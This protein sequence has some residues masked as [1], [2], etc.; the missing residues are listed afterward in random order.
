MARVARL[1]VQIDSTG[2][3]QGA[4]EVNAALLSTA[5][6]AQRSAQARVEA[7]QTVARAT[8]SSN[9]AFDAQVK[10]MQA[11]QREANRLANEER[12][13]A[14]SQLEA[15]AA[16]RALTGATA[17]RASATAAQAVQSQAAA[18]G[19]LRT[20]LSRTVGTIAGAAASVGALTTGT[21]VATGAMTGLTGVL[22]SL[23]GPVGT[24]V[25]VAMSA[26]PA[27]LDAIARRGDESAE[28]MRRLRREFEALSVSQ[29]SQSLGQ[30]EARRVDLIRQLQ[31]VQPGDNAGVNRLTR[32]LLE[33]DEAVG[34]LSARLRALR[35]E[36]GG[37]GRSTIN[38]FANEL[39]ELKEATTRARTEGAAAGEAYRKAAAVWAQSAG[40]IQTLGAA[41]N[42]GNAEARSLYE[43]A[44]QI[45]QIH[46]AVAA[47]SKDAAAALKA[48]GAEQ[49]AAGEAM[50]DGAALS[51][52]ALRDNLDALNQTIALQ[53]A[54]RV[55]VA[56]SIDAREEENAQIRAQVRAL[57]QSRD[58]YEQV[59]VL[60]AQEKAVA[61]TRAKLPP[62]EVLAPGQAERIRAAV[63]ESAE[64]QKLLA[65]MLRTFDQNTTATREW[66]VAL[67]RVGEAAAGVAEMVSA[68]GRLAGA[69]GD[70]G[71]AIDRA[72]GGASRL[73][74]S[75][76]Q[77]QRAGIFRDANGV[78][79]N[80]GIGGAL[81]GAAGI[82]GQAAAVAGIA[83]A[84]GA[85]VGIITGFMQQMQGAAE[86]ARQAANALREMRASVKRDVASYTLG[87]SGSSLDQ[88]LAGLAADFNG[89]IANLLE[90][91][92]P[93]VP[94]LGAR[95]AK[96]VVPTAD[97]VNAV[98]DAY[99]QLVAAAKAAAAEAKRFASLE[100]D[101]RGAAAAGRTAEAEAIRQ[102]IAN[103]RELSEARKAGADAAMLAA[104]AEVQAAEAAAQE[105]ARMRERDAFAGDLTAR[106]Q[107]IRGDARGA[108]VT[109]QGL[110]A[111]SAL[112]EAEALVQ[113]GTITAAMFEELKRLV[114]VEM[115][116]AI[117]DFDAAVE[118][119]TQAQQDDLAIR[120]LVA[121]GKD[122]E[123][124][125]LRREVA[126][127]EELAGVTDEALRAQIL[128][129]QGLE[130]E[131]AAKA[132]AEAAADAA[133]EAAARRAQQDLD[134]ARRWADAMRIVDPV[135]AAMIDRAII[136]AERQRELAEA[137]DDTVRA[138]LREL[139][140][141]QDQ[142]DAMAKLAE[143]M[144]KAKR[145][146]E[147]LARFTSDLESEWLRATGRGFD[148]DVRDLQ[149]WRD[150]QRKAAEAVGLGNDPDTLRKIDDIYNARYRNLIAQQTGGT[151]TAVEPA[152]S[153]RGAGDTPRVLGEDT[154]AFRSSRSIT[155][156]TSLQLVDYAASQLSVQRRILA[157]LESR[158]GGATTMAPSV[159]TLDR[160]FG[161]RVNDRARL[162]HG[163]VL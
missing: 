67:S 2:A 111:A 149:R 151:P 10:A 115:A 103:E 17:T 35:Q 120:A 95:T 3:K 70:V 40:S 61:E 107:A 126:N 7:E 96:S 8:T 105:R 123:A 156:S 76:S 73:L 30:A 142:A 42:A 131:A 161:V 43:S 85:G 45:V 44:L 84:L 59:L 113:A 98:I 158:G 83:G 72:L 117:A 5:S 71:S 157:V 152:S 58:A 74:S 97:D 31:Q 153:F 27:V 33:A 91:G 20:S 88:Q 144:E 12:R 14:Q 136:E 109:R 141:L 52:R 89:L 1:G 116:Q 63:A 137:Q 163:V 16:A 139:Y 119:A 37:Q 118:K 47:S 81:S 60:Q 122:A 23:S 54:A 138:R 34:K 46:A 124:A 87:A 64:L 130:A 66:E 108:F 162:V 134:I 99:E 36:S 112:A 140:A 100:L 19:E 128:Y 9:V 114:G 51:R 62:G 94:R 78:T 68:A 93:R 75:L 29:V 18:V 132:A 143:E 41:M 121:Q 79:Q 154:T 15:A 53:N 155:E 56:D 90:A 159:D 57:L 129:V 148:A 49:K 32:Q 4:A 86:A 39:A 77:V 28:T 48:M 110:G 80:V 104:I 6:A 146:A 13:L 160:A 50:A 145:A 125:Q 24:A 55:G 135:Q 65:D 147:E 92:A 38:A 101:A 22:A 25:I 21:T 82:G 69:F 150:E 127:R 102:Q 26:L 11:A 133:A 106:G